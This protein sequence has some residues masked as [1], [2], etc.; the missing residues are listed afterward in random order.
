MD[1]VVDVTGGWAGCD[2]AGVES[3]LELIFSS[4]RYTKDKRMSP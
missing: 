4:G 1:E 2:G 3:G